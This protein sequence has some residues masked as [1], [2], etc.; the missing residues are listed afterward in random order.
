MNVAAG[1]HRSDEMTT[2]G[3]I[4]HRY[5]RM[6]SQECMCSLAE[7]GEQ[8]FHL[9]AG[10]L[11]A[12]TSGGLDA[13]GEDGFGVVGAI[14]LRES[15]RVHLVAGDVVGIGCK[16][17]AEVVFGGGEIA[18]I[19]AFQGQAVK[20]K[21]VRWI[22]GQQFFEFLATGFLLFGHG[23]VLYVEQERSQNEGGR[24]E[25]CRVQAKV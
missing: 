7:I 16:Q 23:D 15:L 14:V 19:A 2:G 6:H 20:S 5:M 17:S 13:V 8:G 21:G 4:N 22:L 24:G 10:V 1:E 3:E 18:G 9:G 11:V 12:D 25:R